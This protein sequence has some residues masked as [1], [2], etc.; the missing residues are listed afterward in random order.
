MDVVIAGVG[1]RLE[2][3]RGRLGFKKGEMAQAGNVSASA[4]G[5][6]LRGERMPDV[7]A[8][9]A[10]A[11]AGVDPLYVTIGR[12]MPTL[13]TPEEEFVLGGYR[14]LDERGRAGVL[15]LIGGMQ[16]AASTDVQ[17]KGDV[18][19][20]VHGGMKVTTPMNFTINKKSRK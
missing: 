15:A 11:S 8:L 16:P 17:I 9:A 4:Y 1:D 13:L 19:Q 14:K 12:R 20:V 2:E 3:E 10:W 7:A 5:N 18:S 6:Y